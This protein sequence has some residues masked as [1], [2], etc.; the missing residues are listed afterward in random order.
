M[1]ILISNDDGVHAPGLAALAENLA[2]IG[3]ILVVAP[4][5]DRSGASNSLTLDRPLRPERQANGFIAINGTPTDCVLLAVS[6]AFDFTPDLVVSGIN[7]GANL[8]D[9]VI[10]SGTVAAALEGR[11]LGAPA[12][13]VSLALRGGRNFQTAAWAARELLESWDELALPARTILNVNV[14]DLPI[15]EVRGWQRTR[16]GHRGRSETP[17]RMQDPRGSECFWIAAV[18]PEED[19]GEGTDFHAVASGEVSVTPLQVDMTRHEA[20]G[21]LEHWMTKLERA[22]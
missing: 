11:S 1:K 5:R 15:A 12:L 19:A 13:A 21:E 9:D 3:E 10:Y 7:H 18:G 17:L 6:G 22:E 2:D 20:A 4:D 16:L 8:G 14:P